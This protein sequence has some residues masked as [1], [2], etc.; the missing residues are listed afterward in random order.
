MLRQIVVRAMPATMRPVQRPNQRPTRSVMMAEGEEVADGEADDPVADDLDDE[1]GVGVARAAEGAGGGD[2]EAVEE[3][4][5][6]RDE[7]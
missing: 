1:S 7:E 3:L 6:G 5:D 4:E 2:L